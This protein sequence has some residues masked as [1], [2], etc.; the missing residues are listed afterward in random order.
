MFKK[1]KYYKRIHTFILLV[2]CSPNEPIHF[3]GFCTSWIRIQ[4]SFPYADPDLTHCKIFTQKFISEARDMSQSPETDA[5]LG[6]E[7]S[8]DWTGSTTLL[9]LLQNICFKDRKINFKKNFSNFYLL[10][11]LKKF[12]KFISSPKKL[13][14][15]QNLNLKRVCTDQAWFRP[16]LSI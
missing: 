11:K 9:K 14:C 8:Q 12:V 16:T 6:P 15:I 4:V 3:L 7:S 5:Q 10:K 13:N 1:L 2:L